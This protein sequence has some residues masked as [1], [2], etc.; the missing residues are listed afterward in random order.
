MTRIARTE[1]TAHEAVDELYARL[2]KLECRRRCRGVCGSVVMTRMEWARITI[3]LGYAPEGNADLTCPMLAGD[4]C[5]VYAIRPLICRLFGLIDD[6]MMRCPWG[7]VP[8]RWLSKDES[9]A[10]L[11]EMERIGA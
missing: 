7:C 3:R 5:N 2:P 6:P 10:L 1:P 8:E 11:A 9:H 4:H